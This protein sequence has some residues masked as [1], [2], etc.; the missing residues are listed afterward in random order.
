MYL[1]FG[2]TSHPRSPSEKSDPGTDA[3]AAPFSA[4][5]VLG[6]TGISTGMIFKVTPHESA[7]HSYSTWNMSYH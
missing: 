7:E 3:A 5:S 6:L 1:A 2:G 4:S